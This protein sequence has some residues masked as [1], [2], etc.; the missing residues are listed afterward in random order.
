MAANYGTEVVGLTTNMVGIYTAPANNNDNRSILLSIYASNKTAADNSITCGI[1]ATSVA[2]TGI[3]S[4]AII[5]SLANAIVVPAN[6][7][8]E[9]VVNKIILQGGDD[10]DNKPK[11][12]YAQAATAGAIDVTVSIY[13]TGT[14]V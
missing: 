8:L 13:E 14:G 10:T 12:V 4:T 2:P 6:T 11:Y 5:A 9:L 3:T 7:S 1:A